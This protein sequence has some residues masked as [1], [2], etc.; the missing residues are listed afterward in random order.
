[1][2]LTSAQQN[3]IVY[4]LGYGGKILQV[5]SVIYN[6]TLADR[7]STLPADT[8]ALVISLLATITAI[9]TKI[10]D[11]PCRLSAMQVGDIKLNNTELEALRREKKRIAKEIAVHLDIPWMG[12]Y[13][14]VGVIN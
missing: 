8:E 4:L 13:G 14:S 10:S 7:L 12:S 5:G 11:A 6:K 3:K 9:E 1:M 2:A